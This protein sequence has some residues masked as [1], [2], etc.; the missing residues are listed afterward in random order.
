VRRPKQIVNALEKAFG[1]NQAPLKDKVVNFLVG[2][3]RRTFGDGMDL[4]ELSQWC[5]DNS[6][7]PLDEDDFFV[8]SHQIFYEDDRDLYEDDDDFEVGDIF[9]LY[10][11]TSRLIR[12]SR[13]VYLN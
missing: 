8:V 4:G 5:L 13:Y 2:F 11:S 9:R 12:L 1:I 6:E 3:K 10:I 7:V